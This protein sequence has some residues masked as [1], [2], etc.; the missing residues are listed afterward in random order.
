MRRLM[1][2]DNKKVTVTPGHHG[3]ACDAA[4]SLL[5]KVA[6]NRL[7]AGFVFGYLG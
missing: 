7:F 3:W 1:S 2:T 5:K 6:G 4:R